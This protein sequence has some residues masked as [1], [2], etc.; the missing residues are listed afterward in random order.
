[1]AFGTG[2]KGN[3]L[4]METLTVN[5]KCSGSTTT[6]LKDVTLTL[7][8][9]TTLGLV[10]ESG[11]GKSMFCR[12]IL[13]LLPRGAYYGE[14]SGIFYKGKNLAAASSKDWQTI[15]GSD[16][17]MIFQNPSSVLNPVTPI[18]KQIEEVLKKF[19]TKSR[20]SRHELKT[21]VAELLRAVGI[22]D[23]H[24]RADY[25]PH[26]LSGGMCQR[27]AIAI[28]LAARPSFLLADEPTTALDMTIQADILALLDK[29]KN[30]TGMGMLLVSHDL[31]VVADH[32]DEVAVMYDGRI[33]EMA[34]SLQLFTSPRHPYTANLVKAVTALEEPTIPLPSI[35]PRGNVPPQKEGSS[36]QGCAYAPRCEKVSAKCWSEQP[37]L[38]APT[39]NFRGLVR[40]FYPLLGSQVRGGENVD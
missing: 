29:I 7:R 39:T 3:D 27:V 20:P 10:G 33:I 30:A 25:Y 38:K 36:P 22:S 18:G 28:A 6:L 9:G 4:Q 32:C 5:I 37:K 16:I 31:G 19:G 11:C 40:C 23:A 24:E 26:Q 34:P 21:N 8:Q 1:M 14:H 17:S 35:A 15:R 12:A 2:I 13:G